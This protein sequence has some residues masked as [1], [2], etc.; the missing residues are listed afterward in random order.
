MKRVNRSG[1]PPLPSLA[2][3]R[4]V[5][6]HQIQ[7]AFHTGVTVVDVPSSASSAAAHIPGTMSIPRGA[8]L[9]TWAGTFVPESRDIVLITGDDDRLSRARHTLALIGLDRVVA[10]AGQRALDAWQTAVGELER[11]QRGSDETVS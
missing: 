1:P 6:A 8:S 9:A 5:G 11:L 10:W 3:I 7:D 2:P 4:E